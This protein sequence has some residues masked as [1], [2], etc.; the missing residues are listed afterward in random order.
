MGLSD[1][2]WLIEED[3]YNNGYDPTNIEDVKAYWKERLD[4]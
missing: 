1:L 4:D 3:M 2:E